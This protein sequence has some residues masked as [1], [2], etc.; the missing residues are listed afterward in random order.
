MSKLNLTYPP[1]IKDN[2]ALS[3]FLKE[4]Y[5]LLTLTGITEDMLADGFQIDAYRLYDSGGSSDVDM[6]SRY[7]NVTGDT[8]TGNLTLSGD[9]TNALH[10]ATKQYA[11]T[12]VL[13]AGDTMTG[14]LTLSDN[15]TN[16]LHPVTKQF[17]ESTVFHENEILSYENELLTW[18]A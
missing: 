8:M 16:N 14:F 12:F 17:F 7:V 13:K 3:R 2:V 18:V 10:A 1:V 11:D 5:D 6:D 15:P 9:P 4:L